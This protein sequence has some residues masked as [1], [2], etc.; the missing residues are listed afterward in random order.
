VLIHRAT[1]GDHP[2]SLH[3]SR[4][5]NPTAAFWKNRE[6]LRKSDVFAYVILVV[7][8]AELFRILKISTGSGSQ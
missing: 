6:L 5:K 4:I 8:T 7:N 3:G 2:S 1:H